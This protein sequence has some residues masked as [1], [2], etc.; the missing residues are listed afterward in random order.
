MGNLLRFPRL[1]MESDLRG[2]RY[3]L[4]ASRCFV[5][6]HENI[7]ETG[8]GNMRRLTPTQDIEAAPL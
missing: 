2:A 7:A 3:D 1:E 6:M 4:T 5:Q 8:G